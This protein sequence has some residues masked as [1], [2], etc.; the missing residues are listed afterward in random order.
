MAN[1]NG[2]LSR[3]LPLALWHRGSDEELARDAMQQSLVTHGHI[4]AQL[5]CALLCLWGAPHRRGRAKRN[6]VGAGDANVA[7]TFA[8]FVSRRQCD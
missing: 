2:S 7:R 4:R 3:V 1:G 8:R 6:R 5:C